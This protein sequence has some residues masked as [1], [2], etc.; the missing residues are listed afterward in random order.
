MAHSTVKRSFKTINPRNNRNS[1]NVVVN[2]GDTEM[3]KEM[4]LARQYSMIN[5]INFK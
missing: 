2:N 5:D 4:I 1:E 3:H